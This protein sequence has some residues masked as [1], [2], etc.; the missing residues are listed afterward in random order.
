MHEQR[1]ALAAQPRSADHGNALFF[2]GQDNVVDVGV[3]L[4]LSDGIG[5]AG[6]RHIGN[7]ADAAGFQ[8]VK[9]GLLPSRRLGSGRSHGFY[10]QWLSTSIHLISL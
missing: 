2:R 8:G 6:V 9:H 1:G 5:M 7:L 3:Q 10:S 4:G